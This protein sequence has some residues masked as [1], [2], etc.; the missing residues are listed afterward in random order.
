MH[1]V[2]KVHKCEMRRFA[3]TVGIG[4]Y[5]PVLSAKEKCDL[6]SDMT[7][8]TVLQMGLE[9]FGLLTNMVAF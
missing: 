8:T 4:Y 6:A 9:E 5:S 2:A 1:A 3:V 7:L